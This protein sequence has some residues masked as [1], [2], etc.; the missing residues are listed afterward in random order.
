[1]AINANYQINYTAAIFKI[2][3][4]PVGTINGTTA[5]CLNS[6]AP[7]ITF[8]ATVGTA[9]FTFTYNINGGA[10]RTAVVNSPNTAVSVAAPTTTAGS[11]VY[12]LVDIADANTNQALSGTATVT[13]RQLATATIAGSTA[14]PA[15][16]TSPNITFT[17]ANGTAPYTFTYNINGGSNRTVTTTAGNSVTV[18]APTTTAGTFAYNLV[19]VA[20]VNC[21]QVQTGTATI[22]IRPLPVATIAGTAS[23][24]INTAAPTITFTGSAGTAPYTFTYTINGGAN[25]T[26]TT[27][28]NIATVSAPSNVTGTFTYALVNVADAFAAQSQTGTAVVTINALPVI[29]LSKNSVS[30]VVSKG[31]PVILTAAGGTT[32]TWTPSTDILNGQGTATLMVRPRQTTTYTVTVTNASGCTSNQSITVTVE[33]DFKIK[34]INILTPNGDGKNDKFVIENIDYYPNNT[35]KIFDRAGRVVFSKKGYANEWD[36]TYNGTALASDTYYYIL[37][38]GTNISQFKG[39][40]TI[41]RN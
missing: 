14:V 6:T 38:F 28:S 25:R 31:T 34:P 35:L 17:G 29:T 24:C 30:P 1:M 21:G 36:G 33:E 27:S 32:Y 16:S 11:F 41:V 40:I 39:Y 23:V 15:N 22:I 18:A 20:D 26:V 3:P 5:V 7:N 2:I 19:S 4:K 8:T 10:N 13:V 9:P 12:N 37:D